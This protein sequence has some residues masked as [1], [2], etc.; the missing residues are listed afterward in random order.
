MWFKSLKKVTFEKTC[1]CNKKKCIFD[2]NVSKAK[3]RLRGGRFIFKHFGFTYKG[4]NMPCF[5]ATA[6]SLV[7]FSKETNHFRIS[8]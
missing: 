2:P 5:S 8:K 7:L 4:S 6:I 1:L 3:M